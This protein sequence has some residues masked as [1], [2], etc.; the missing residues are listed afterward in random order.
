MQDLVGIHGGAVVS[1]LPCIGIIEIKAAEFI[2]VITAILQIM[3]NGVGS[4]LHR[5]KDQVADA[6]RAVLLPDGFHIHLCGQGVHIVIERCAGGGIFR[7]T[8]FVGG[9]GAQIIFAGIVIDFRLGVIG[10]RLLGDPVHC[11]GKVLPRLGQGFLG[12]GV[13]V[14]LQI[15][16][17]QHA[18]PCQQPAAAVHLL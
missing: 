3:Q 17:V 14:V 6:C 16:A 15:N 7:Q 2:Q 4:P 12:P 18:G 10:L 5:Q 8:G 9:K 13:G 11:H 1:F